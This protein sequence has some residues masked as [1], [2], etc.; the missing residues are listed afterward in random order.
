M[1]VHWIL[2]TVLDDDDECVC[3]YVL[4]I[5]RNFPIIETEMSAKWTS[6]TD[7]RGWLPK[8]LSTYGP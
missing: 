7:W 6:N 1:G 4:F 5:V 2:P 3:V 8:I